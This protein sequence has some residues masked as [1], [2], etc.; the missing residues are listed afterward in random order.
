MIINIT[1]PK[2]KIDFGDPCFNGEYLLFSFEVG[3]LKESI[4]CKEFK[5]YIDGELVV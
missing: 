2:R 1:D 5:T 4:I 3:T